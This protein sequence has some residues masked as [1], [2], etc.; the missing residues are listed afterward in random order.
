[1]KDAL[2]AFFEAV[3]PVEELLEQREVIGSANEGALRSE[4]HRVWFAQKR[5]NL[6]C[7][8]TV[9]EAVF[10]FTQKLHE[11]VW[12]STMDGWAQYVEDA[13]HSAL[14]AGRTNMALPLKW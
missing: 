10:K 8:E 6:L 7:S 4:M 12:D 13:R 11:C 1:M 3:Q 14:D 9:A 5:V 2:L